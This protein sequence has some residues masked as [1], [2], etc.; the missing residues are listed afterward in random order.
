MEAQLTYLVQTCTDV[1]MCHSLS[2][3][4]LSVE[5]TKA[6]RLMADRVPVD[7]SLATFETMGICV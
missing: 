6:L 7:A 4:V 1:P 3:A 5:Q 2:V